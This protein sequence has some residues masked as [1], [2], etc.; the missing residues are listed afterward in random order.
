M[1]VYTKPQFFILMKEMISKVP[2]SE[3]QKTEETPSEEDKAAEK[4]TTTTVVE[5]KESKDS[6]GSAV[7]GSNDYNAEQFKKNVK[8]LLSSSRIF[9]ASRRKYCDREAQVYL[10]IS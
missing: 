10:C 8:E 6:P 9:E 3:E 1:I 4:P 7:D 2:P 5:S